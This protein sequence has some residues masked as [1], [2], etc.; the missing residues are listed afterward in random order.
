MAFAIKKG[1]I[2]LASLL[3]GTFGLHAVYRAQAETA[4]G[5]ATGPLAPVFAA[6]PGLSEPSPTAVVTASDG[7]VQL[8]ATADRGAVLHQGMGSYRSR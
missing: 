3:F 4:A 7:K 5:G 8:T 2:V 6:L 1:A